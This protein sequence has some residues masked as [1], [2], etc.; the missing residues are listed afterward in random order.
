VV[1]RSQ[2]RAEIAMLLGYLV[3]ASRTNGSNGDV[4]PLGLPSFRPLSF[5]TTLAERVM[6][7]EPEPPSPAPTNGP[8]RSTR[9]IAPV[10]APTQPVSP[11]ILAVDTPPATEPPPEPEVTVA[12]PRPE[13]AA[14][15]PE[16][17]TAGPAVVA[18]APTDSEAPRPAAGDEGA[19]RG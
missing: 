14:S 6:P 7:S 10:E 1:H 5:L 4:E 11:P 18:D 15:A 9:P 8:S 16:A 19:Q 13:A 2:L 3:P 12:A 17:V